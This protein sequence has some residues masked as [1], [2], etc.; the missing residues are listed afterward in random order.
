MNRS[1]GIDESICVEQLRVQRNALYLMSRGMTA[2]YLDRA[3]IIPICG[4]ILMLWL[5]E[6]SAII[7]VLF[8]NYECESIAHTTIIVFKLF[9]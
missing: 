2:K 9:N 3:S 5:H 1:I 4:S 6:L 7:T 8:S